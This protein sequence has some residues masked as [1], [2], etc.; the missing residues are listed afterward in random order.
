MGGWNLLQWV[1][2]A[3]RAC[4]RDERRAGLADRPRDGE[5]SRARERDRE[6]RAIHRADEGDGTKRG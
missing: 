6:R 4:D 5:D 1:G 3:E 2:H